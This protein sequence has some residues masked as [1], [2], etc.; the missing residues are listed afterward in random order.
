[1]KP[2]AFHPAARPADPGPVWRVFAAAEAGRV[3][4]ETRSDGMVFVTWL[5]PAQAHRLGNE[6]HASALLLGFD[7]EGTAPPGNA[8]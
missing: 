6:L 4:L 8:T 7:P 2:T 3:R 1:M 5:N